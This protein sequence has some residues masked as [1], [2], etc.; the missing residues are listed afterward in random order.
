MRRVGGERVGRPDKS[1][2]AVLGVGAHCRLHASAALE[3]SLGYKQQAP[4]VREAIGGT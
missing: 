1:G 4:R 3:P 2:R